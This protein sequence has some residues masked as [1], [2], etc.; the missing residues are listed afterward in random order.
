MELGHRLRQLVP[1]RRLHPQIDRQPQRLRILAQALVE[2][3]LGAGDALRVHVH[4]A[5]HVGGDAP[6]R[7]AAALGRL[8]IDAGDAEV[9][10]RQLLLRADAAGQVDELLVAAQPGARDLQIELRQHLLQAS[11]RVVGVDHLLRVGIQPGG[12]HRERQDLAVPVRDHRP[13]ARAGVAGVGT[14]G[15]AR[16]LGDRRGRVRQ[17]GH[18]LQPLGRQRHDHRGGRQLDHH[19]DEQHG[20]PT[21]RQ[22]QPPAA[23]FQGGPAAQVRFRHPD[24]R[25]RDRARAH[26]PGGRGVGGAA[27][28][29]GDRSTRPQRNGTGGGSAERE[30]P[31]TLDGAENGVATGMAAGVANGAGAGA[32]N[33]AGAGAA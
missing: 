4:G 16:H 10:D 26:P 18:P 9:V 33:G 1:H 22:H 14:G 7:V 15:F 24:G 29:A 5:D 12:R 2:E 27:R 11:G 13:G 3:P 32:A 21:S 8:E 19:R 31:S 30:P 23:L 25:D 20:E 28:W 6:L 17:A